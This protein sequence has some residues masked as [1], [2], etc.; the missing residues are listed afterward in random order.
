MHFSVTA[1]L[2]I[3]TRKKLIFTNFLVLSY[4]HFVESKYVYCNKKNYNYQSGNFLW[5]LITWFTK[6]GS[7][8]MLFQE[9]DVFKGSFISIYISIID[10]EMLIKMICLELVN[11]VNTLQAFFF[12]IM[13][14]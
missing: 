10:G 8:H 11:P 13:I 6:I 1:T 9:E 7:F 4:H 2:F 14:L 3:S 12:I 5:S